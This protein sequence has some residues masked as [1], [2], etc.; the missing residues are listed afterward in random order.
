MRLEVKG[1]DDG[2]VSVGVMSASGQ[3]KPQEKKPS[4]SCLIECAQSVNLYMFVM[5]ACVSVCVSHHVSTLMPVLWV[6]AAATQQ[7]VSLPLPLVLHFK[8]AACHISVFVH[9]HRLN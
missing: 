8:L 6:D 5:C 4:S 7:S 2:M 1:K 3:F 9:T